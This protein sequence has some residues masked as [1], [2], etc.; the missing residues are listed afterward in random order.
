MLLYV[1][2][3]WIRLKKHAFNDVDQKRSQVELIRA[4]LASSKGVVCFLQLPSCWVA[5]HIPR[6]A[7]NQVN[8][9]A[10]KSCNQ[11]INDLEIMQ[12]TCMNPFKHGVQIQSFW[13][14]TVIMA[15]SLIHSALHYRP[16]YTCIYRWKIGARCLKFLIP[17]FCICI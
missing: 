5:L 17:K 7:S 13:C 12:R 6:L 8:T 3:V 11:W 15:R 2:S 14:M 4:Q 1:L 16:S 9:P 10:A